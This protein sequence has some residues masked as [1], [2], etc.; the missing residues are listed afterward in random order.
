MELYF[1]KGCVS[2][3]HVE[4]LFTSQVF[5]AKSTFSHEGFTDSELEDGSCWT[6]TTGELC[7]SGSQ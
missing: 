4:L 2:F 7:H 3:L 5:G 1:L 6:T